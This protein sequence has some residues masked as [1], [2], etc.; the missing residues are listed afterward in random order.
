MDLSTSSEL[1]K[2]MSQREHWKR[3]SRMAAK[4]GQVQAFQAGPC[5]F[6]LYLNLCCVLI[7]AMPF[8]G[9]SIWRRLY[10]L[11]AKCN[12]WYI[13]MNKLRSWH[14]PWRKIAWFTITVK[15]WFS[16]PT[17]QGSMFVFLKRVNNFYTQEIQQILRI[18]V[19]SWSR[20]TPFVNHTLRTPGLCRSEICIRK[21]KEMH[22]AN[23]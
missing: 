9:N 10:V 1:Y 7:W 19:R 15:I 2:R 22:F 16:S 11:W 12:N 21:S 8:S 5:V 13:Y 14:Y 18:R 23:L 17:S 20:S 6:A 4:G 3:M